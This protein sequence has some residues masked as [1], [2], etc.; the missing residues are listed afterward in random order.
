M[1]LIIFCEIEFQSQK[2]QMLAPPQMCK[3]LGLQSIY[4]PVYFPNGEFDGFRICY[5]CCLPMVYEGTVI[6]NDPYKFR[7]L[8]NVR[9]Q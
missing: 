2:F 1:L 7:R 3:I 4:I 8:R 5:V 6:S 9:L